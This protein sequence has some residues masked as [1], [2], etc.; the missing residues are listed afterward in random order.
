MRENLEAQSIISTTN[1]SDYTVRITSNNQPDWNSDRGWYLDLPA[2]TAGAPAER[3]IS[4][5][6]VMQFET[7]PDRVLFVT[8]V[9]TSDP[10][11][12]GGTSWLMELS[13]LSGGRTDTSIYDLNGDNQFNDDDLVSGNT[14]SGIALPQ[15][16][17]LVGTPL[18][19]NVPNPPPNNPEEPPHNPEEPP[20]P[21]LLAK[22]FTGSTGKSGTP[23]ATQSRDPDPP[24]NLGNGQRLHWRELL[25]EEVPD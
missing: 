20:P 7:V 19:V 25:E 4:P 15:D 10:C 23:T 14:V 13:L 8:N 5:A 11:S 3:I 6:L 21:G 22:V 12:R 1:T 18:L 17:G 9:V 24:E 2:P 16:Y